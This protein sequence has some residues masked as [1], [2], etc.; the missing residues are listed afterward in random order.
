LHL[1][2]DLGTNEHNEVGVVCTTIPAISD[3]T[4]VH[5]LSVDVGQ[6]GIGH[7]LVLGQVVVQHITADGQVTI[8]EVVVT[9]PA[10]RTELFTT[11]NQRVEHAESEQDGL[12]LW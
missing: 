9:G 7:F 8:V 3:V 11:H 12:V 2:E 10:L 6:I 5:D 1:L 4:T